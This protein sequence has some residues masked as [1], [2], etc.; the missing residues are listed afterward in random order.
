METVHT[1]YYIETLYDPDE[2]LALVMLDGGRGYGRTTVGFYR[3]RDAFYRDSAY[4]NGCGNLYVNLNRLNPDLYGRAADRFKPFSPTRYTDAEVIWRPRLCVDLDPVRLSGI[5]STGDELQA[6]LD[7]GAK[8]CDYITSQWQVFVLPVHSGNGVQIVFRIDE[9]PE[10]KL[11]EEF[12]KHLDSKFTSDRVK[13]DTGLSDLARI[14]R[15]PGTLNCKGDDIPER[16]RRMSQ[17]LEVKD[18]A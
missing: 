2:L 4:L 13:V 3:D 8:V 11:V 6:A 1:Q 16:P 7:L 15:L 14:V 12:L 10:S 18:A 5:N 17:I 9:P